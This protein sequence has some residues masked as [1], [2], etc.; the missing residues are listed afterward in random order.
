VW[1]RRRIRSPN[2]SLAPFALVFDGR[3]NRESRQTSQ[4][5][6]RWEAKALIDRGVDMRFCGTKSGQYTDGPHATML[7]LTPLVRTMEQCFRSS[8]MEKRPLTG[9]PSSPGRFCALRR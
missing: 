4:K 6:G 9:S 7:D 3:T 2:S 5:A 1:T 8:R